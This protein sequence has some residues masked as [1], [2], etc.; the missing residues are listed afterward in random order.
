M[1]EFALGQRRDPICGLPLTE[2]TAEETADG[3][4]GQ[5]VLFCSPG[6]LDIWVQRPASSDDGGQASRR[7][8]LRQGMAT[9][10][11]G[12]RKDLVRP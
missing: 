2:V 5:V 10:H 7:A 1:P 8:S 6:C 3:P 11:R 9:G 12:I 4:D